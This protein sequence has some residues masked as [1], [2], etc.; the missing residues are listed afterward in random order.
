M[1][2][3]WRDMLL[4]F[5]LALV[6]RLLAMLPVQHPGYMDAAYSYDIALNLLDGRGLTEPFLWNYLDDPSGLP[7]PSHL[8]WMPLPTLLAT[9]SMIV[10]GS[11]YRPA[12]LPFVVL[13]AL[14]PV[15][16]Y[17]VAMETGN[18]RRHAWLA[19]GLTVFSGFYLRYWG[20]TD[21]FA[22]FALTGS[23]CLVAA[24]RS[25]Q[26]VTSISL[27]RAAA[28]ALATGALAGLSHLAR[29]DT[30]VLL[31]AVIVAVAAAA[32]RRS[33][34]AGGL[35][36]PACV[37]A[38]YI[39]VMLPWFVRNTT[40]TG[41]PF[42][43]AG[44]QAAWLT[45]YDDLFSYGRDLS[46]AGYLAWGWGNILASKL[47]AAW[48]N[49]QTVGVVFGMVF[50]TPLALVGWVQLRHHFLY[51][52][53]GGYAVLLVAVMT[54]VFTFP[55]PRGALF[56]SGGALLP[57][58]AA[59]SLV[60]L[61][62]T[63]KWV[64]SRHR[65][66]DAASAGRV[67]G[68][69][70]VGLAMLVSGWVVYRDLSQDAQPVSRGVVGWLARHR[71]LDQVVM[72]NDPPSYCYWGG[73]PAIV[74]PNGPVDVL[75]AAADRYAARVVILDQNRPLPL[76]PLYAG[77]TAHPRLSLV[78]TLPGNVQIYRIRPAQGN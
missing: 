69:G 20:Q 64:A 68:I 26:A 11:G 21:N 16:S 62:T 63:T 54:L 19:A 71:Q 29:A 32:F 46:P 72:T 36:A 33:R 17:W 6:V 55:G 67:F 43:A 70:L 47:T 1:S 48:L 75:L 13:S 50:L 78:E 41:N 25:Q 52:L 34:V 39:L 74:V 10:L 40:V 56:H 44:M 51:R 9:L 8:Y 45:S 7:H 3:T 14:L 77:E 4:V 12:Q 57:F 58:I 31:L 35:W 76:A 60:G 53:V 15:V 28:W 37:A 5:G 42:P 22:P 30:P 23:L 65:G 49:V 38:G 18:S 61:D 27:R 24:W 66:W 73:G 59:S 2:Q